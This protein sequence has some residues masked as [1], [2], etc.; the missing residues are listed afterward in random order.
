[1]N[2]MACVLALAAGTGL[3]SGPTGTVALAEPNPAAGELQIAVTASNAT[4]E[5][6]STLDV[7]F[8]GGSVRAIELYLDGVLMKKQAMQTREGR[9]V[10]SF[11]LDGISAGS[12]SVLIKAFDADGNCATSTAQWKVS[13][14][15]ADVLARFVGLRP[16][17]QVQGVLPIQLTIDSSVRNPYVTFTIDNDFLACMNYAPY[18]YNWDTTKAE[19][20][21]HTVG[22]EVLDGDSLKT[23]QTL[24]MLVNVNNQG[25]YTKIHTEKTPAA[26][27]KIAP[28][29][30]AAAIAKIARGVAENSKPGVRMEPQTGANDLSH[31]GMNFAAPSTRPGRAPKSEAFGGVTRSATRP[32]PR[33]SD[34][35]SIAPDFAPGTPLHN[36]L[37]ALRNSAAL[38]VGAPGTLTPA[39][40]NSAPTVDSVLDATLHPSA[41]RHNGAAPAMRSIEPTAPRITRNNLPLRTAPPRTHSMVPGTVGELASPASLFRLDAPIIVTG[42]L[43]R[44]LVRA[45][46]AGNVAARPGFALNPVTFSAPGMAQAIRP[47]M[48]AAK[49]TAKL[50]I[51]HPARPKALAKKRKPNLFAEFNHT[52]VDFDVPTR[53]EGGIPLTPF[54]HIFEFT[55]GAIEWNDATQ[56]V[57]ATNSDSD[58]LF[59][60]G[61]ASGTVNQQTVPMEKRSYLDHGRAI[62]PVSFLRDSMNVKVHYDPKT[63]HLLIES[64]K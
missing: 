2:R 29:T 51:A 36:G 48:Q 45:R 30:P 24:S 50:V 25:G 35:H 49:T 43:S 20:G 16:N 15:E 39:P 44:V 38:R 23:V 22:V 28:N 33:R 10:I 32:A 18:T 4:S 31:L 7:T 37:T 42:D 5:G 40:V 13:A 63:G 12:H 34:A 60:I 55:G 56:T 46:R 61:A 52:P 58:I 8:K 6:T 1:M 54:R 27:E 64:A 9:G 14:Q 47:A 62:V 57:H 26:P 53:S 41:L 21:R 17:V 3:L 59:Q 11:A 19:N